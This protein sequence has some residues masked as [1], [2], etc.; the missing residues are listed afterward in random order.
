MTSRSPTP[1]VF[2]TRAPNSSYAWKQ[3]DGLQLE[4]P[5]RDRMLIF[6]ATGFAAISWG[7]LARFESPLV[8]I[9]SLET[10][11]VDL[12]LNYVSP[13]TPA[14][15][16]GFNWSASFLARFK[17]KFPINAAGTRSLVV[18]RKGKVMAG[19]RELAF[20]KLRFNAAVSWFLK[21]WSANVTFRFTDKVVERCATNGSLGAFPDELCSDFVPG[22]YDPVT[23]A[24]PRNTL[25]S[26]LYTDLR[27]NWRP[28]LVDE[29]LTLSLGSQQ[30]L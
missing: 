19:T 8:N 13:I 4:K 27:I 5:Q 26:T 22:L 23:E 16:F 15:T 21:N 2:V 18:D 12:N 29:R 9:S 24:G 28:R 17:E 6:S 14:G 7:A 20:P 1:S 11:G 10:S 3:P 25:D 30:S